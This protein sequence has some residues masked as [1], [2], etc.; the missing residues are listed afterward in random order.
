M[1]AIVVTGSRDGT[2]TKPEQDS[3]RKFLREQPQPCV[4]ICGDCTGIDSYAAA[5]AEAEGVQV[6]RMR[7]LWNRYGAKAGPMRNDKMCDVAKRLDPHAALVPWPGG[8]GTRSCIG[9]ASNHG[10]E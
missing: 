5:Y 7:A 2:P 9:A 1:R 6:I 10:M 3:F 4:L 8:A